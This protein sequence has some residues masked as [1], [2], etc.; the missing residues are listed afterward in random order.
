MHCCW[1]YALA[2]V[3]PYRVPSTAAHNL[4]TDRQIKT[5]C[6][7]VVHLLSLH[8]TIIPPAIL[9]YCFYIQTLPF[10]CPSSLS[11]TFLYPPYIIICS[12]STFPLSS[13]H[14]TF[15]PLYQH[16]SLFPSNHPSSI[17][18]HHLCLS[19]RIS[20]NPSLHPSFLTLVNKEAG[21]DEQPVSVLI[22][23]VEDE[24]G[25]ELILQE[26]QSH[27]LLNVMRRGQ[28]TRR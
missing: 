10:I 6:W 14:H 15:T 24:S 18:L 23:G 5:S 11:Q 3:N 21:V 4:Q 16:L 28:E 13:L 7:H 25:G 26:G 22:S 20:Q 9:L 12:S 1:I 27:H 19:Q 2:P 17:I 8:H